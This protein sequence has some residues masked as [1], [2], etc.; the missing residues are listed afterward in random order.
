MK[1]TLASLLGMFTLA[2]LPTTALAGDIASTGKVYHIVVLTS[3]PGVVPTA[4]R[5]ALRQFGYVL[6]QNLIIEELPLP[7]VDDPLFDLGEELERVHAD[8]VVTWGERATQAARYATRR[9]PV[10]FVVAGDPVAML[11]VA[12]LARPGGNMTG[13]ALTTSRLTVEG[14]RWLQLLIPGLARLGVIWKPQEP[15]QAHTFTA[16]QAA[17]QPLGV[18][19]VSIEARLPTQLGDTVRVGMSQ[20]P[21]AILVLFPLEASLERG[22]LASLTSVTRLPTLFQLKEFVH[23]GG[24]MSYGTNL[25]EVARDAAIFVHRIL[26]GAKPADIPVE[27]PTKFELV[28]N[29]K[30][31]KALGLMIPPS[32]LAR[33]DEV[34]Q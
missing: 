4:F 20:Q 24:L 9:S 13:I 3:G 18:K 21:D 34:I 32:L 17:A 30:T 10:V 8:V 25:E 2:L 15:G 5:D 29:L 28:I 27:Q 31:A 14:V 33:A 12:D 16:V 11:L 6:H 22:F 19:I 23:A 26:N 7:T 1:T